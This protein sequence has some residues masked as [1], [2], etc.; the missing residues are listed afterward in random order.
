M[1]RKSTIS[2]VKWS[3]ASQF[4][5]Q[6]LYFIV[7][8]ILARM[9]SPSDFGL[10]GMAIVVIGFGELFKDL[11]T[12]AAIIHKKFPS[13]ALLS[14][15][16][17][18]NV[19]FGCGFTGVIFFISPLASFFY[20]EP[21]L[22]GILHVLSLSFILSGLSILHNA[23]LRKKMAFDVLA[24]IELFAS[25]VGGVIGVGAA[26][27]GAGVW[28]LVSQAIV[29]TF[30]TTICLWFGS[31]WRPKFIFSWEEIKSVYFY[32]LNLTGYSIFNYFA[33]NADYLLIG[34]Y[35][36]TQDLGYYTLAYRLM[37]YPIQ[38]VT[39]IF[40]KV[41]FPAFS[42]IKN[43]NTRFRRVYL[44]ICSSISII[45]FPMM[46]GLWIVS[47]S[48]VFTF[49][50]EKWQPVSKLLMILAPVGMVQSIGA[51][52]GS[53]YQAKGKT[54]WM[55]RW[56]VASG[57]FV[58]ICF[59]IGIRWGIIGVAWSY[60]LAISILIIPSFSI[61]FKLID[62]KFCELLLYLVRPMVGSI[63]MLSVLIVIKSAVSNYLDP[64]WELSILITAG[65][66]FYGAF[67]CLFN[68]SQMLE[69]YSVL[70]RNDR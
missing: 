1:F 37:L 62:L 20:N 39:S 64:A 16:F 3:S 67:M 59:I 42:Q 4:G 23:L 29:T 30:L 9:L 57:T 33:R 46:V 53:I 56:G 48:F 31:T 40:G 28:S 27:F 47:E 38:S 52:V 54:D 58:T 22:T 25:I 70:T 43:D 13:D 44:K 8:A 21:R 15:I 2:G 68:K 12:S 66:T 11:G 17:W 50:G 24:K 32:S 10:M 14:S 60:F 26:Y 5:R 34:R 19:G 69:L 61:P 65:I 49:V 36:G 6:G 63:A 7:T 55:F 41:L 18:V 51:T 35:L 45:T